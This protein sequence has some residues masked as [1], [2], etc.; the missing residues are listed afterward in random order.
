MY[1][2]SG[3]IYHYWLLIYFWG[4]IEFL[5]TLMHKVSWID[6]ASYVIINTTVGF[7]VTIL[8]NVQNVMFYMVLKSNTIMSVFSGMLAGSRYTNSRMR[9][10]K[11][12][13]S[14]ACVWNGYIQMWFL[15]SIIYT[16]IV[17]EHRYK[18][19]WYCSIQK[20]IPTFHSLRFQTSLFTIFTKKTSST[21][22]C[23]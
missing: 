17:L 15:V 8:I 18:I 20:F 21:L 14:N 6:L 9:C 3:T 23:S 19:I 12:Y 16:A 7:N 4:T 11:T 13:S 10:R 22:H 1:F 2:M 5:I